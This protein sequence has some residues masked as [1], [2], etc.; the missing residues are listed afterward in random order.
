MP[1]CAWAG[2][3]NAGNVNHYSMNMNMSNTACMA[4]QN[5]MQ[6]FMGL[7]SPGSMP[8]N[9]PGVTQAPP[10]PPMGIP[11][12]NMNMPSMDNH[13]PETER[14]SSS[15]AALR[16]KAREHSVAAAMGLFGAYGK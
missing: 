12:G 6:N 4:P 7:A 2:T 10:P 5:S 8:P 14:R 15:I 9:H 1:S 16:L 3:T 13:L 11:M